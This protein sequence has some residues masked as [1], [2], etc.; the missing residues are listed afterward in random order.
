VVRTG[1]FSFSNWSSQLA[2]DEVCVLLCLEKLLRFLC[3]RFAWHG[4]DAFLLLEYVVQLCT[5]AYLRIAGPPIYVRSTLF[6]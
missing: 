2:E 1:G 3:A 6:T 5:L 4:L